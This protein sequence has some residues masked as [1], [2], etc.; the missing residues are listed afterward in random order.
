M[1]TKPVSSPITNALVSD[2]CPNGGLGMFYATRPSCGG[3]SLVQ[4]CV[5]VHNERVKR[6]CL[7]ALAAKMEGRN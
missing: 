2:F 5:Q 7:A 6:V 3:C 1:N 4:E